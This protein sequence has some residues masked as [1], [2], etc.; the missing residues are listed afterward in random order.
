MSSQKVNKLQASRRKRI[1]YLQKY[2]LPTH[3]DLVLMKLDKAI[4]QESV[5]GKRKSTR[6]VQ[7]NLEI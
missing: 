7:L 5:R 6:S 3:S 1:G 2:N 4:R